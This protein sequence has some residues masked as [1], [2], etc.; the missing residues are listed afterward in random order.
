MYLANVGGDVHVVGPIPA[1]KSGGAIVVEPGGTKVLAQVMRD[2]LTR[3]QTPR[4]R[5]RRLD[6]RARRA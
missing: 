2:P 3:R 5:R 4:S 6:G 1:I